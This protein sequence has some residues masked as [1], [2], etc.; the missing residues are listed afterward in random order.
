MK[1]IIRNAVGVFL[2]LTGMTL[3]LIALLVGFL[4]GVL[5]YFL[6]WWGVEVVE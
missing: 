5:G 6:T 1:T 4:P 3:V 2:I